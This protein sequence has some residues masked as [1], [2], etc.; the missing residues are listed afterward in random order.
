MIAVNCTLLPAGEITS[1]WFE[2][3]CTSTASNGGL[4]GSNV[5]ENI[6]A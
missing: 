4:R 5:N 1:G 3:H 2:A 6:A